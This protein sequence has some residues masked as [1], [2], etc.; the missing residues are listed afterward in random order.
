MASLCLVIPAWNRF[1]LTE[2]C[3][4]QKQT[5]Q[6]AIPGLDVQVVV[7][8]D[9]EN[10]DIARGLGFSAIERDND[11]GLGTKYNDGYEWA[12]RQGFDYVGAHG[13][14]MWMLPDLLATLPAGVPRSGSALASRMLTVVHHR[15]DV[16]L[17]IRVPDEFPFGSAIY[18]MAALESTGYRPCA[19][20]IRS[21]CDTSTRRAIARRHYRE[22]HRY[23]RMVYTEHTQFELINFQ[24]RNTQLTDWDRLRERLGGQLVK[25]T[26][27][28]ELGRFYPPQLVRDV[29]AYYHSG[30][31]LES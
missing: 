13:S 2:I 20:G 31:S 29:H 10:L 24:S 14:D 27:Y 4:R 11:E 18:P 8:A 23:L 25:H 6:G 9:D 17:E 3:L 5:L 16:R 1:E 26:L 12:A 28:E 7:V 21:G 15:G 22:N 19:E 30:R